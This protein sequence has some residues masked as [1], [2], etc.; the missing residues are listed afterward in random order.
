MDQWTRKNDELAK[1]ITENKMLIQ[2]KLTVACTPTKD[3][4]KKSIASASQTKTHKVLVGL[5]NGSINTQKN[6]SFDYMLTS[7]KKSNK[8]NKMRLNNHL[9]SLQKP[10]VLFNEE[11]SQVLSGTESSLLDTS[12]N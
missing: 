12:R 5:Q 11:D 4:M 10:K 6:K 1:E 9:A 3:M 2:Q 8:E 7:M